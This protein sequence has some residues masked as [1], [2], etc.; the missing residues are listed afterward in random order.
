[1]QTS[2]DLVIVGAGPAGLSL[3]AAL[4]DAA[5]RVALVERTPAAEL[6][7]PPYDGREIALTQASIRH[8]QRL[9][10]WER[11]SAADIAPFERARVFNGGSPH[12]LNFS[13]I[14][15]GEALGAFVP[16]AAIRKALFEVVQQQ[17]NATL[18][19]GQS[20]AAIRTAADPVQI[21]LASGESLEA[22]LAIGADTR[23][24][25]LRR[26]QG[27]S[28]RMFDFGKSMLVCRLE[29]ERPHDQ[30]A[31]EWFGHGQTIAMLPLNGSTSS[32]ILTLPPRELE[33]L[34]DMDP[35][36]FAEDAFRRTAGRWGTMKLAS[37]RHAYPLVAVYA[38]R[39]V[40]RRFA[41]VGDAAVGMHPVTA[42][43]YNFGL[44]G[45]VALANEIRRSASERGDV[46]HSSGLLRY[47]AL[48]RRATLPLFEATNAI[49][50]LYTDDHA[51]PRLA[52]AAGLRLMNAAAPIRHAVEAILSA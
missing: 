10:V 2:F 49:A 13:N 43:G 30:T 1:V 34:L 7:A 47:E 4:G 38:N 37:T 45:A 18:L 41:L 12:T 52:R 27:I 3:A 9:G 31:T 15:R 39:F 24:S 40:A 8:L 25:P 21:S 42:H 36:G 26:S 51:L 35:D 6:A 19:D 23:F 22:R 33:P 5:V 17:A 28:A 16:N 29:H 46:G 14:R 50:R 44:R 11:L 20:V 32:Y 48:H